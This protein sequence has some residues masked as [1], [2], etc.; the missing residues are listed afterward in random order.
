MVTFRPNTSGFIEYM[1]LKPSLSEFS[2]IWQ[3]ADQILLGYEYK[4]FYT[5][6]EEIVVIRLEIEQN[7]TFR[8]CQKSSLALLSVF[9]GWPDSET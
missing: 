3:L 4:Y 1:Y 5:W 8:K 2:I 9:E 7:K 6:H